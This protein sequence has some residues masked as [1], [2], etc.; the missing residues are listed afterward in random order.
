[1]AA[2]PL[3]FLSIRRSLLSVLV[4]FVHLVRHVFDEDRFEE[5][6]VQAEVVADDGSKYSI[7]LQRDLER[8]PLDLRARVSEALQNYL[9]KSDVP[10]KH[11]NLARV[12]LD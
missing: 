6:G 8:Q 11:V 10:V 7:Q 5:F 3:A 2:S 4:N 9:R 1:M 12:L